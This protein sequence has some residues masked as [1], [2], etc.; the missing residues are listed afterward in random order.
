MKKS[1]TWIVL[2]FSHSLF[3]GLDRR[4]QGLKVEHTNMQFSWESISQQEQASLN[5][6]LKKIG[7]IF[8]ISVWVSGMMSYQYLYYL[9]G[10]IFFFFLLLPQRRL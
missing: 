2:C 7:E 9:V 3:Q 1:P 5:E 4:K 6:I 10:L 8:L